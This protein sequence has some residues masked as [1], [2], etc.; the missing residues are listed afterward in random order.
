MLLLNIPTRI[1][2]YTAFYDF[3]MGFNIK[4]TDLILANKS[5]WDSFIEPLS[6]NSS[7]IIKEDYGSGEPTNVMIDSIRK[8]VEFKKFD[9]I[10]AVGGGS[11]IDIAKLLAL[12]STISS[13][14]IFEKKIPLLRTKKLVIVPTTCGTGS[15]VTNISIAEIVNKGSKM[16]IS[17]D[18]L[19]ADDAVLI[20]ELLINLPYYFYICSSI[21]ALIHAMESYVS[22]RANAYSLPYSRAAIESIIKIFIELSEG[23]LDSRSEYLEEMLIAS[24]LAGLAFS[25]AGVGAVHAMS[26][27]LSGKYHTPH[28]EAN[29]QFFIEVFELYS[30]GNPIKGRIRELNDILANIFKVDPKNVYIELKKLL[31]RLIINKPL[32]EY[33]VTEE[34]VEEFITTVEN[35]QQR[36]LANNYRRFTRDEIRNIYLNRL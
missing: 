30:K 35:T 31:N 9:R 32:S 1:H 8:D 15:E 18:A 13:V 4:E 24:N 3:V 7:V 29:Y 10:I 5:T 20:P 21:D 28:G 2:H 12:R 16:G 23:G 17:D 25:N 6:L 11:V 27:P 14:D 36:L 19:F 22:P 34:D 33:G 26:Y